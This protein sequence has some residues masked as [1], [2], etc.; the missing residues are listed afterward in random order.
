MDIHAYNFD[1]LAEKE[2]KYPKIDEDARGTQLLIKA[3]GGK[4]CKDEIDRIAE[5]A[6]N[7]GI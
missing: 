3:A 6:R 2:W 1:S 7:E 4:L 5:Q